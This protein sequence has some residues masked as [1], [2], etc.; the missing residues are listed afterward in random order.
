VNDA[1]PDRDWLDLLE[2]CGFGT[3]AKAE[4]VTREKRAV[5]G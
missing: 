4:V 2:Q 1:L 3:G 5:I